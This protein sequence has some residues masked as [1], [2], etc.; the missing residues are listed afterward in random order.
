M[1][2]QYTYD[3]RKMQGGGYTQPAPPQ[4][5]ISQG[6]N[7]WDNIKSDVRSFIKY[8]LKSLTVFYIH[9]HQAEKF[10]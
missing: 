5:T 3:P 8:P 9:Q 6:P 1:A 4:A 2:K 10:F 7:T